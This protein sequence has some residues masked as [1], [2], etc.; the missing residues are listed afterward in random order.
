[1]FGEEAWL[2]QTHGEAWK[3]YRTHTPRWVFRSR[4]ALLMFAGA[5]VVA[6]P[7][8]GLAYEMVADARAARDFPPPGTLVDIGGRRLHLLCIG[9]GTPTV[10]F[11]AS[12]WGN[13]LSSPRARERLAARTTVC[14]YD[15]RGLG[16]SDPAPGATTVA[17]LARDLGVLQDRAA[18][19]WPF[20]L[21]ASSIGGLT[22]EMLT[23]QFPERVAGLVLVDAATSALVPRLA[24]RGALIRA[25]GCAAGG[26][27][28]FGLI[29]LLDPFALGADSNEAQRGA[30]LTYSA[31]TWAE[32]C[33]IARGL[34]ASGQEL[35]EAPPLPADLPLVVLS[36][37]SAT[38]LLPP[39]VERFVDVR[40][41]SADLQAS[42]REMAARSSRGTWTMVPE[43]THLIGGSQPDAVVDAVHDLLDQLRR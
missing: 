5:V 19:Q 33:A 13:A 7:I 4:K 25:A 9:E 10:I 8:A 35:E 22:A 18:L 16:W 14:S 26:L 21:V 3:R 12:G 43:S 29:R 32:M 17:G 39:G 31:K 6:L 2:L 28:Q 11:E 23:R 20:V 36:A 15:R 40:A 38:D 41:L 37:S 42:H 24:S 30:A 1:V 34:A 27:A